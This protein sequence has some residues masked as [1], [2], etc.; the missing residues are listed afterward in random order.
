MSLRN[1]PKGLPR[2]DWVLFIT[3]LALVGIGLMMIFAT[4]YYDIEGGNIFSLNSTF[5]R[6]AIWAAISLVVLLALVLIDWQIFNS[7]A[8]PIYALGI[9]SLV[10][11]LLFGREIKGATSWIAIGPFRYSLQSLLS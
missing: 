6:Q 1:S 3:Y 10:L 8:I 4:T 11:V 5:G 2:F 7:L 9:I